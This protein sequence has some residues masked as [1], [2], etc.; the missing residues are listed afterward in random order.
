MLETLRHPNAINVSKM[1]TVLKTSGRKCMNWGGGYLFTP[2][3]S[4]PLLKYKKKKKKK[5]TKLR[6]HSSHCRASLPNHQALPTRLTSLL[7][8]PSH[9]LPSTPFQP[10]TNTHQ[11]K[12]TRTSSWP[13]RTCTA[14]RSITAPNPDALLAQS[15]SVSRSSRNALP[16]ANIGPKPSAKPLSELTKKLLPTP[17]NYASTISTTKPPLA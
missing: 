2:L 8:A 11:R 9:N 7:L 13:S 14:S 10:K 5:K 4:P 3:H 1:P 6:T 16:L 12:P 17:R 15:S